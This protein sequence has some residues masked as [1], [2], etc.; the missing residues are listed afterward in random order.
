[1]RLEVEC[2]HKYIYPTM[3][4]TDII[5]C[6]TE[7]RLNQLAD[8]TLIWLT[9]GLCVG[10][11]II[12]SYL[13][14]HSYPAFGAG[15][16]LLMANRIVENSYILPGII[17]HYTNHGL[18]F[19]YP[20]L[21]FYFA[22]IFLDFFSVS[23]MNIAR[24]LPGLISVGYLIP[25]FFLAKEILGS[26]PK[27]G[28]STIILSVNPPVLQWHVSAG[29][30]IR[31]L[32]FLFT[33][34]GLYSSLRLFRDRDFRWLPIAIVTL[35]LT[36]LTHPQYTIFFV[37]S[38]VLLWFAFDRTLT[39][40]HYG[41][42]M[43]LSGFLFT[44]PWWGQVILSHGVGIFFAAAGAQGGI[45]TNLSHMA[46]MFGIQSW[47]EAAFYFWSPLSVLG[48]VYLIMKKRVF[49]PFWFLLAAVILEKARFPFFIG[50]FLSSV[51]IIDSARTI[52]RP[53]VQ[54]KPDLRAGTSIIVLLF[55]LIGIFTGTLYVTSSVDAHAGSQSLPQF[56]DDSDVVAMQ[57]VQQNTAPSAQ[58]IVLGDAAEWFPQQTHRTILVGPWGVEWKGHD[59][60]REQIKRFRQLS[61]CDSSQCISTNLYQS[62]LDPD[63][64]YVP[65]QKFTVRGMMHSQ[66]KQT[67]ASFRTSPRYQSVFENRGV[68]IFAVS[69]DTRIENSI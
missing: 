20:P 21:G 35:S 18:P 38:A 9:P 64:I 32:A 49:L 36:V 41:V 12:Y 13:K 58:F 33:L 19:A 26:S 43:G 14:T 22:A 3:S 29:G 2:S 37:A 54:T 66:S 7:R 47:S 55:V 10:I 50:S 61:T 59:T 44:A 11:F 34:I 63:Y 62:N 5:S 39:G 30:F 57:W 25:S 45:G 23:P 56:I 53:F 69:D 65:K 24:F 42:L 51:L 17:P 6:S 1:M 52:V 60:Y 16:Y 40:F 31:A 28:L 15:L 48:S 68:A 67:I 4:V 46:T 8:Q 27:A